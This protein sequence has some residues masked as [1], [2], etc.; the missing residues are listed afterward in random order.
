MDL[1]EYNPTIDQIDELKKIMTDMIVSYQPFILSDNCCTGT[2]DDWINQS[3]KYMMEK[4]N[5]CFEDWDRFTEA[6]GRMRRMYNDWINSICNLAGPLSDLTVVDTA[7][8]QGYFLYE[9]LKRG[10]KRAVAYDLDYP[11]IHKSYEL[12]NEITGYAVEFISE[13]YDMMTHKIPNAV[14]ADIVISSAIMLHL[15]DPTYYLAFL[16]SITKKLL[17]LFTAIDD[18]PDYRITY[19]GEPRTHFK[20]FT[21]PICFDGTTSVSRPL[22]ELGLRELGFQKIIELPHQKDWLPIS[23]YR[24]FKVLIGIR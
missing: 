15:S 14:E 8:S 23:W 12:L 24:P 18:N 1:R 17:F 20:H 5:V 9:L 22:I 16:G 13:P 7:A 3:G 19:H 2:A 10:A 11:P 4:D 6:N 21:F